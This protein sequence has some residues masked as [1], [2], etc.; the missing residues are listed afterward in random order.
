[1]TALVAA[2]I[3]EQSNGDFWYCPRD[4]R[5]AMLF[6][7]LAAAYSSHLI[8]ITQLIH[9]KI[10]GRAETFANAFLIKQMR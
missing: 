7:D 6:D 1:L 4:E 9:S 3:A 5:M 10:D 8:E 2:G